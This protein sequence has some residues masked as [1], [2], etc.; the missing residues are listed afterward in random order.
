[1]DD[2]VRGLQ[3]LDKTILNNIKHKDYERVN[4]LAEE[5][6]EI[7]TGEGIHKHLKRIVTREEKE[8]FEQRCRIY[9]T[10]IPSTVGNLEDMFDKP[11]RSNGIYSSIETPDVNRRNEIVERMKM[12]YQGESEAGIDAYMYEKWKR[13]CVYDPNAYICVEFG[14][15]DPVK[16]KPYPFPIEYSSK[17]AILPVYKNGTLDYFIAEQSIIYRTDAT[18]PEVTVAGSKYIMYLENNAIVLIEVDK[19]LRITELQNPEFH[20]VK[21]DKGEVVRVFTIQYFETKSKVVPLVRAGY[22][23]DPVTK[24]R[25]CISTLHHSLNFYKK[26]LKTGSEFDLTMSLHAFPVRVQW[27]KSCEGNKQKGQTCNNGR[28]ANG[29]ICPICKGNSMVPVATSTQDLI[30]VKPPK[31]K[32]DPVLDLSKAF[33]Y[34][35]PPVDFLKFQEEYLDRLTQKAKSAIFAAEVMQKKT[36]DAT[37]TEMD[38]SYDNVYDVFHPFCKK[39]SAVWMFAVRLIAI[40][41]DNADKLQLYHQF[42]KDFKM[43]GIDTLL[44]EAKL[45]TESGLSQHVINAIQ[46]DILDKMYADDPNTLTKIRIKNKFHP[47][48]GKTTAEIQSIL[49]GDVLPFYKTL[50]TYFD[51]IFDEIDNMMSDTFYLMTYENQKKIITEKVSEILKQVDEQKAQKLTNLNDL[52]NKGNNGQ[53]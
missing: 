53:A 31:S 44:T 32:D 43:K 47:F 10:T 42:P 8:M 13:M 46:D 40:Y 50:Y 39:Y 49:M 30:Y 14:D 4:K 36:V 48:S 11:L 2:K 24:G 41:T 19:R 18:K 23:T 38:Y 21:N 9:Q 12:F 26:E 52:L 15:F 5:Y 28:T 25:T 16:N 33:A 6:Y 51:I 3:I 1:M 29:A 37:A 20:E 35:A 22:K 27:G 34:I 7:F 45:A 17:E